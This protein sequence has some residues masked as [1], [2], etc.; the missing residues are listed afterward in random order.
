[1]R[2]GEIWWASHGEPQ[3][4]GPGYR[5][6]VLVVQSNEFNDSAIRTLICAA[7]TSNLRLAD[8]PGNV[9][10]GRRVG[11]LPQDSVVDVSQLITLDKHLLTEKVGRLPAQSLQDVEAGIKLVLAL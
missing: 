7:I 5:R 11:G 8:A 6:P 1:V 2:R 3:G 4:S 10:V 9:R